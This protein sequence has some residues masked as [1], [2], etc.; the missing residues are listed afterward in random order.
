MST[1]L[2][3][4]TSKGI[5]FETALAFARAGHLVF[6]TMRNPASAPLLAEVAKRES[7]P[8][9]V[10]A[11]DVDS[12]ESVRDGIA[13]ILAEGPID[14]LVNNAGIEG[15]GSVEEQPLSQ[16]R[17]IMETN[18]FGVIRCVQAV[19]PGMRER[20][21]GC[22]LNVSSIAGRL[23]CAPLTSY[24]ASKWALEALTEALAG[25]MKTFNVR[26]ALVEPGIIDTDMAQRISTPRA[27]SL[28]GQGARYAALFSN[29]L[30]QP[31]PASLVAAKIL[32]I[33]DSGTWQLRHLVGPDAVP[34]LELRKSMTDEE[35]V[36]LNAADDATFFARI[37]G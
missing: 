11:M 29:S 27:Q 25:E 7:L 30:Q 20:R 15:V 18:Y 10:S 3:T 5:G 26:V 9:V 37:S 2:I 28:Y 12:D 1:I 33:V 17:A 36:D 32:D 34:F 24:C 13:A 31:V 23:S 4:G 6:A 19:I 21:T 35:W 22:I 14:V 16:F 8:I